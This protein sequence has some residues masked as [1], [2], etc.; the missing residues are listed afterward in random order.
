MG[1][2]SR[3]LKHRGVILH[4]QPYRETSY[5]LDIFS[6]EQGFITIL[7]KGI[8]NSRTSTAGLLETLNELD[9]VSYKNPES[10]WHIFKSGDVIKAHLFDCTYPQAQLLLAAAEFIRQ[11]EITAEDRS[12]FYDLLISYVTYIKNVEQ[13]GI[14]IFWRYLLRNFK[15]LGIF[16]ETDN[17]IICNNNPLSFYGFIPTQ[18]G[19]ICNNC[20]HPA[21][22]SQI[23][24]LRAESSE[25]LK[26]LSKIGNYLHEIKISSDSGKEIT[27]I[28]LLHLKEHFHKDFHLRSLDNYF[29]E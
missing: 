19:F 20:Y 7:A 15:L 27:R 4:K 3:E 1:S 5:I 17:C 22:D 14:A 6:P 29:T 24:R 11:L 13:N 9:F 16:L 12:T 26:N 28:L 18:S 23:I 10:N 2:Q 8:K 21:R 25:L